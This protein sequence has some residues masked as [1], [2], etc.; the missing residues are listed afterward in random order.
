MSDLVLKRDI[1]Y[2]L[3]PGRSDFDYYDPETGDLR[4]QPY[5][6]GGASPA[7]RVARKF[8]VLADPSRFSELA[9]LAVRDFQIRPGHYLMM[10]D[11]SPRSKDSRGWS[12]SDQLEL[13]P[14]DGVGPEHAG[15]L[16]GSRETC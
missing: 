6:V 7:E 11:N 16:G 5:D 1:Y 14:E 3:D 10:G 15:K 13:N 9:D 4:S 8:E 2:T 12:T